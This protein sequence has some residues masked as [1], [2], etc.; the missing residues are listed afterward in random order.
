MRINPSLGVSKITEGG[1]GGY[2]NRDPA[3]MSTRSGEEDGEKLVKGEE[4]WTVNKNHFFSGGG[5]RRRLFP[6]DL[7]QTAAA[8]S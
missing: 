2:H 6:V 3:V 5:R 1:G 7:L 4:N 8:G